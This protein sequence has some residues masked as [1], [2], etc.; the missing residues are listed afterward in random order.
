MAN[1]SVQKF[2]FHALVMQANV[3]YH[4]VFLVTLGHILYQIIGM[5]IRL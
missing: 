3:S 2:N 1:E 4:I 5:G